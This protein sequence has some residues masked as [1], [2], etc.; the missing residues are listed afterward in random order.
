MTIADNTP[1]TQ[2]FAVARY[3]GVAVWASVSPPRD[4]VRALQQNERVELLVDEGDGWLRV[5]MADGAQGLVQRSALRAWDAYQQQQMQQPRAVQ[6]SYAAASPPSYGRR[7]AGAPLVALGLNI[8]AWLC[9][10]GGLLLAIGLA[11]DY[12]CTA[13]EDPFGFGTSSSDCDD[14]GSTRVVI[15]LSIFL[16]S[17]VTALFAWGI[18]YT[19]SILRHLEVK[20]DRVSRDGAG[21]AIAPAYQPAPQPVAMTPDVPKVTGRCEVCGNLFSADVLA[22]VDG[23]RMCRQCAAASRL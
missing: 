18:A 14:E 23:K 2:E 9:A 17:I 16:P 4:Q 13:F 6:P 15:F 5:R 8:F 20:V 22:D 3:S 7:Y 1:N 10:I 12:D 11:A 19:I 21:A